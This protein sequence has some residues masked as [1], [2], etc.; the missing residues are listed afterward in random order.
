MESH[1]VKSVIERE[2]SEKRKANQNPKIRGVYIHFDMP[3]DG[4]YFSMFEIRNYTAYCT[5][6]ENHY[7]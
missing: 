1:N 5:K 7:F 4:L 6:N 2:N 3:Q